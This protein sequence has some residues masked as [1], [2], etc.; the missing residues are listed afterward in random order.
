[1]AL[2]SFA[3]DPAISAAIIALI[4]LIVVASTMVQAYLGMGFGM[5]AGPL[6][7]LIDPA[8][9]PLP[10]LVGA[11]IT[12]GWNAAREKSVVDWKDL[13]IGIVGRVIGTFIAVAVI[14]QLTDPKMFVLCLG[15]LVAV[16][17]LLSISGLR[18]RKTPRTLF[19]MS[20]ISGFLGTVT[21]V[22][23]PPMA[24]VY[25]DVRPDIARPTLSAFFAIGSVISLASLLATGWGDAHDW[26]LSALIVPPVIIGLI[27]A[28][29]IPAKLDDRFR[30]ALLTLSAVAAA[31][32]IWRGL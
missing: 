17:V 20:N 4:F 23:A 5:A 24:L 21:S 25:Q 2:P 7:A 8:F 13:R 30:M 19:A 29:L 28:R 6:L 9:V 22:G 3:A 27:L 32:L 26:T 16:A 11:I 18:L 14:H 15:I 31:M 10:M 12:A 1:M